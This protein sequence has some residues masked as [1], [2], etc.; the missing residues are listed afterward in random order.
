MVASRAEIATIRIGH[1]HGRLL[2][3]SVLNILQASDARLAVSVY[4]G[5]DGKRP[6]GIS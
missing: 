4:R 2:F 1:C 3:R 6:M 5:A